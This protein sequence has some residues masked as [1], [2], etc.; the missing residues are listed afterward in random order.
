MELENIVNLVFN[1]KKI[2][3]YSFE[4]GSQTYLNHDKQYIRRSKL[5]GLLQ[6]TSTEN[7]IQIFYPFRKENDGL[8]DVLLPQVAKGNQ[9]PALL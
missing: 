4:A 8:A 6:P 5:S 9:V 3:P 2:N 7:K 1:L